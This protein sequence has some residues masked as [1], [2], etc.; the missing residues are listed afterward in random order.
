V[1]QAF[2]YD[3]DGAL[4]ELIRKQQDLIQEVASGWEPWDGEGFVGAINE[5]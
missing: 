2:I 3:A 4:L 1:K 5:Q